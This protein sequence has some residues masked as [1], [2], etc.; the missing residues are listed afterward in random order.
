M[1]WNGVTDLTIY[2]TQIW[3]SDESFDEYNGMYKTNFEREV[4]IV[5][6]KTFDEL[7]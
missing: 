3:I 2:K 5:Q 4:E 7:D 6:K 1:K